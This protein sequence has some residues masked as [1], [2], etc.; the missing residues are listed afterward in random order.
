MALFSFYSSRKPK[1]FEHKPIYYNPRKEALDERIHR[2]KR[3]MGVE[4][5]D[6]DYKPS[7]K[8][9]FIEGTHHL[10]RSHE[11]GNNGHT[12][13]SKSMKLILIAVLLIVSFWYFFLR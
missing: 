2:V 11:R 1:Q 4:E 5:M 6:K 7:I 8:G 12:L 3:E 13:T 9:T 10:K